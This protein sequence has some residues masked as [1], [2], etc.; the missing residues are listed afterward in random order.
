MAAVQGDHVAAR[1]LF[2]ESLAIAREVGYKLDIAFYLEGLAAVVTA[3][4]EPAWAARLWGAAETLREAMGTPIPPVY[5]ARYERSVSAARAQLGEKAFAAAWAEGR[6]L[7]LEQVLDA[8]PRLSPTPSNSRSIEAMVQEPPVSSPEA[9]PLVF[10]SLTPREKEVL[11]LLAQGL[12]SAH[13]AERL[14]IGVVTVN[15]HVRSIYSKLG[16]T[17][18]SAATRYAL[19]HHLV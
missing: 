7:T 14:V 13:I 10:A 15:F 16:E 9:L 1:A 8:P 3:Q 19:E 12:T 18:R 6:A 2:E 5:R 4:G 11:R 17:S